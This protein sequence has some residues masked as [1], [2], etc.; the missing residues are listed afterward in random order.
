MNAK[1]V[2]S[3]LKNDEAYQWSREHNSYSNM[4]M[5][6][7]AHGY[8]STRAHVTAMLTVWRA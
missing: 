6:L 2:H 3:L 7:E 8:P 4:V 5:V 1:Q